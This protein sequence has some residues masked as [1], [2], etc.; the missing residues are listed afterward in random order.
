MSVVTI[1]PQIM[2]IRLTSCGGQSSRYPDEVLIQIYPDLTMAVKADRHQK[3]YKNETPRIPIQ[4]LVPV[5]ID[6]SQPRETERTLVIDQELI[7]DSIFGDLRILRIKGIERNFNIPEDEMEA[8]YTGLN[9][10]FPDC[11]PNY[12]K[13]NQHFYRNPNKE[14]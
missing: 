1:Y 7:F 4:E 10:A 2:D 12:I 6:F 11:F 9:Q 5:P 3:S 8:M 14:K 13:P